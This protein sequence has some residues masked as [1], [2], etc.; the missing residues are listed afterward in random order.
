[1]SLEFNTTNAQKS[2][3]NAYSWQC[4]NKHTFL[5]FYRNVN[6]DYLLNFIGFANLR[7]MHGPM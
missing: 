4:I 6:W 1:M 2:S 7:K 5:S 3:H